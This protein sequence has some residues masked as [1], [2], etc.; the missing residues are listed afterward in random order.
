MYWA[1]YNSVQRASGIGFRQSVVCI[2]P[3]R[4]FGGGEA[5]PHGRQSL[6]G[7]DPV[8]RLENASVKRRE[9]WG[10]FLKLDR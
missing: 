2:K 4:L 5:L 10:A 6:W 1:D 7:R 3:H 8:S 9:D